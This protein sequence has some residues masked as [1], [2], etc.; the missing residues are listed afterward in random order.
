MYSK[1]LTVLITIVEDIEC[2]DI[3]DV[4][5]ELDLLSASKDGNVILSFLW[6]VSCNCNM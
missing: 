2:S 4:I 5:V 1:V 3:A 6:F